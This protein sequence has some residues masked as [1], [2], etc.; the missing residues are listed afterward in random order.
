MFV[1]FGFYKFKK[2]SSLGKSKKILL[3]F[4]SKHNIRGTTIISS[5]GINGS[6]S[7]NSIN[8]LKYKNKLKQLFKF[9]NSNFDSENTS[10]SKLQPFLKGK[11]KIKKEV[12]PM[13]LNISSKT[14][15]K[16]S[17]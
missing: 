16:K 6:I 3:D 13:C 2:L 15:K 17:Y 9:W 12:V 5:E 7:G 10:K 11:V 1:I 14:K 8:V 4:I